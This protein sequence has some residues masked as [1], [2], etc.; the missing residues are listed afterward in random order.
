MYNKRYPIGQFE[1]PLIISSNLISEWISIIAAFPES[2]GK[3]V[4]NLSD[5]QLDTPYRDGGWT[6]RQVV[7][8]CADSHMNAFCRIKLALTEDSPTIKPYFED[9]WAEL[10]DSKTIPVDAS[11]SILKGLHQRWTILLNTIT[12]TELARTFVHPEHDRKI[13]VA[14]AI[15][16]YSWH[17][18]HHLAHIITLKS[19]EGW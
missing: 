5:E 6:L 9:R 19:T 16:M 18:R 4:R 12:A 7:H 3:E 2:L 15:G 8:H 17:C 14:E 1:K 10:A 11:I 13:S